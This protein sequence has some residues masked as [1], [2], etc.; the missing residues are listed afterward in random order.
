MNTRV[1]NTYLF[2]KNII[3]KKIII[4]INIL[5]LPNIVYSTS[6]HTHNSSNVAM[7]TKNHS[8]SSNNTVTKEDWLL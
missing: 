6:L 2:I 5:F 7:T 1:Y 8:K 3:Y 4:F